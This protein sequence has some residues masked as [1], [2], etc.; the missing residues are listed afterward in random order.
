M[1]IILTIFLFSLV[2]S[3]FFSGTESAFFSIDP[4]RYRTLYRKKWAKRSR[5]NFIRKSLDRPEM[6]LSMLLI[7]NLSVNMLLSYSGT[8]MFDQL[9]EGTNLNAN[10]VSFFAI[11]LIVL[12]FGEVLPKVAAVELSERW[13]H[14]V[15]PVIQ[16]WF[17]LT[18]LFA[19]PVS[20]LGDFFNSMLPETSSRFSEEELMEALE[21]ARRFGLLR[22]REQVHLNRAVA[23]FHDTAYAAM[24][25]RSEMLMLP[26]DIT[27]QKA[28]RAFLEKKDTG[29]AIIYHSRNSSI[30]G[31]I[32]LRH[33]LPA[34]H[35]KQKSIR[36]RIQPAL[37][38]PET[39][40]LREVL[41]TFVSSRK[42]VGVVLD[43]AGG[44]SGVISIAD[45]LKKILGELPDK[46]ET[47]NTDS[48]LIIK[49]KKGE[50]R[51]K[52]NI[53]L[54]D[55]NEKFR[56]RLE[57]EEVET[58][59]GFLL[60]KLDGFPKPETILKVHDLVFSSMRVREHRIEEVRVKVL[61]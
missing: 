24:H 27:P 2:L 49:E 38:F 15:T 52:A 12:I 25:P 36:N 7:G 19:Y 20:R 23:F 51:V 33:L 29:T 21:I 10:T 28:K 5:I 6:T 17:R 26:N 11:T 34:L 35:K 37:F 22:E 14:F 50:Y 55:F 31:Y 58:L 32:H 46:N 8:S 53:S 1:E 60:E 3:A 9:L 61:R 42:E 39:L 41:Q 44:F 56:K 48:P 30:V 13:A 40:P 16:V 43:E 59:A 54:H 47:S 45:V 18:Y 57:G 4:A